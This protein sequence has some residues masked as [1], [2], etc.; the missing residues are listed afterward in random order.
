MAEAHVQV[1]KVAVSSPPSLGAF[2]L[3]PPPTSLSFITNR[4][5]LGSQAILSSSLRY[6]VSRPLRRADKLLCSEGVRVYASVD[7]NVEN[8]DTGFQ[9]KKL[10]VFVS[11]GGSNFRALH[12]ACL[13][14]RIF[15]DC[16][17]VVSDK[18]DCK[19]CDYAEGNNIPVAQYPYNKALNSGLSPVELVRTLRQF[20]VDIVILAGYLKLV[21]AEVIQSF[22]RA[23]LNIHPALLPA[24]GGKGFYGR[25]VHEAVIKSG[26]RYSGPTVHFVDEKYDHG[27]IVAQRVVPVLAYDTPEDLAA[28]VLKEEHTI[29]PEVVA[30]VCEDRIFWRED[31]VPLIRRSWDEAEYF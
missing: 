11:G 29:Y 13:Q 9:R 8:K 23:I 20:E 5:S 15:G 24:F 12:E 16:V 26:A 25:K 21:P 22:P 4:R 2:K 7:E 18:P 14:N 27:S 30:A 1:A 3:Q 19:A 28:R 10:A 17:L 31:G 6:G